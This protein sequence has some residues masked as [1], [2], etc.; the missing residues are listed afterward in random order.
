MIYAE[1]FIL[2]LK[3]NKKAARY[4]KEFSSQD[5]FNKWYKMTKNDKDFVINVMRYNPDDLPLQ[6]NYYNAK[7]LSCKRELELRQ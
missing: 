4:V 2:D 1:C 3:T 7:L 5:D 6:F